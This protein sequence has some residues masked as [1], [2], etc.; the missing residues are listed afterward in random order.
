MLILVT[1]NTDVQ[2]KCRLVI[3][4]VYTGFY[5]YWKARKKQTA[6]TLN[7]IILALILLK[8]YF[9]KG[10]CTSIG[11]LEVLGNKHKHGKK[12][13]KTGCVARPTEV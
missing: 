7:T 3:H 9:Q 11:S 1:S 12:A 8:K 13:R 6:A 2:C 5:A 4:V 10:T